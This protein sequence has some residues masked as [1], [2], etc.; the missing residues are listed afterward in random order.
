MCIVFVSYSCLQCFLSIWSALAS[1]APIWLFDDI[2]PCGLFSQIVT[3]SFESS[4]STCVNNIRKSW[5]I[6]SGMAETG[7]TFPTNFLLFCLIFLTFYLILISLSF[8]LIL[9]RP[10]FHTVI[11]IQLISLSCHILV[12][13][14]ILFYSYGAN[15]NVIVTI[16]CLI[17][18][19]SNCV[20]FLNI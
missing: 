3:H 19:F 16:I 10:P 8:T 14:A 11:R 5:E 2:V 7:N 18:I 12:S 20:I 4:S 9:G 17:L 15:V 13:F 6:I 1:S